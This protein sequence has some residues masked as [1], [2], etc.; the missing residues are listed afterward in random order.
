[1]IKL[2]SILFRAIAVVWLLLLLSCFNRKLNT[3]GGHL[4][5]KEITCMNEDSIQRIMLKNT[6][7][8]TIKSLDQNGHFRFKVALDSTGQQLYY[9]VL[10]AS[11]SLNLKLANEMIPLMRFQIASG[12]KSDSSGYFFYYQKFTY[13]QSH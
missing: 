5:S 12:S 1:M 13:H 9:S 11:D 4:I 3:Q 7:F 8:K 2:N 10:H 6:H